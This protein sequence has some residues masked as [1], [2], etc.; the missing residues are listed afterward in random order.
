MKTIDLTLSKKKSENKK[1]ILK[2]NQDSCKN[3]NDNTNKN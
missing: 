1:Q 3:H 2:S